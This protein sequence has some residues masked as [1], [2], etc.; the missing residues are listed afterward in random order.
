MF[1]KEVGFLLPIN[2]NTFF[3]RR[4]YICRHV[5]S[6]LSAAGEGTKGMY[7]RREAA[8]PMLLCSGI[9]ASSSVEGPMRH[10][11]V[12]LSRQQYQFS[13]RRASVW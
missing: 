11:L 5:T 2:D 8:L 9:L 6:P 7:A 1:P 4:S 13:E 3:S 10:S 12:S